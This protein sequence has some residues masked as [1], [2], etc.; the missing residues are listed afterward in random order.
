[1]NESTLAPAP[2][3]LLQVRELKK[4]YTAPHRWF[5]PARPPIQAVDGV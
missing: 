2:A 4:H 1:M 3:P 5:T